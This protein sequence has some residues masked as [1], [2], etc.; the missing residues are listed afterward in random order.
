MST[1][2]AVKKNGCI[3][4]AADSLTTFGDT[5]LPAVDDAAW[6]KIH[7]YRDSHIGIVG[8]AAHLL[9]IQSIFTEDADFDLSNRAAIFETFRSLH[10]RLKEEYFLNPKED[11]DD[12][13]ESTR[14]DALIANPDGIFGLFSLRE[15]FEYQRFWAVG[16]GAD[17]AL[18]AMHALWERENDAEAIARA[19]VEAGAA[20][21]NATSL[22][23]TLYSMEAR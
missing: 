20:F 22:P 3:V 2:V 8:S 1:I 17:Y 15:V 19:G 12:A 4:I 9:V 18:G 23:M 7:R 13:Y 6:D 16:S 11:E 21:N 14:M 5:R 10:P